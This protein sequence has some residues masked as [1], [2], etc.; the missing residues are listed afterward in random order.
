MKPLCIPPLMTEIVQTGISAVEGVVFTDHTTCP[1]CGGQL[2]GYDTK[3]KQFARMITEHGQSVVFVSV[4]RFYCRQCSRICYADE[5]FYP[6]T[7]IGSVVID[8]CIALSMTMPA[9]RV[10]AY[11]EAMGILVHRMSCRLY[12]R[13]SSNNSMRNSARNMEANNMFG[14][15]MPRSILS[16]SGLALELEVGN[17]IKGPDVLAACG[18]PSRNRVFEEGESLKEPWNMPAGRDTGDH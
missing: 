8:L 13:N 1:A 9:N 2:S 11:L 14:V 16:L 3:K 7:R 15:H 17:Q 12:I 5:P 6:N 10:A 18:Y 4:K